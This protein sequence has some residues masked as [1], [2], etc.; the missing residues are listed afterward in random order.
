VTEIANRND[1]RRGKPLREEEP[2]CRI[3]LISGRQ[4]G[5]ARVSWIGVRQILF[6]SDARLQTAG[7]APVHPGT[8][9]IGCDLARVS[10][11]LKFLKS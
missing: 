11:S 5:L 1:W 10:A 4:E 6:A 9:Q 7:N 2:G 8:C 3:N